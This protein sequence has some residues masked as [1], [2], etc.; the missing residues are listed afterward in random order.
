MGDFGA[1][2]CICDS[3]WCTSVSGA[4]VYAGVCVTSSP[5]ARLALP[6]TSVCFAPV[7]IIIIIITII[8]VVIVIVIVVVV[9]VVIVIIIVMMM[10]RAG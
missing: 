10:F 9:I 4:M 3:F 7:I 1:H 6:A 8:M 2:W 5:E